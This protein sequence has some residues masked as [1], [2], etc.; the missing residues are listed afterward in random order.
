MQN[1]FKVSIHAQTLPKRQVQFLTCMSSLVELVSR[2]SLFSILKFGFHI[3]WRK[4]YDTN[5]Y[6]WWFRFMASQKQS[7]KIIFCDDFMIPSLKL[8]EIWQCIWIIVCVKF[9]RKTHEIVLERVYANVLN[10]RSSVLVI[11]YNIQMSLINSWML[12]HLK[13]KINLKVKRLTIEI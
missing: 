2:R 12:L 10:L 11:C 8:N 3:M 4:H 13:L 6:L 9:E 1:F 5:E 7:Q